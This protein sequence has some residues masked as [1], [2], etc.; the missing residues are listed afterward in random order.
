MTENQKTATEELAKQANEAK[1]P[2]ASLVAKGMVS[3][4]S[5]DEN[6]ADRFVERGITLD[7]MW[8]YITEQARKKA[9]DGCACIED[10]EVFGWATHFI[11]DGEMPKTGD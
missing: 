3:R 11:I 8:A 5:E 9:K 7:A 10:K 4:M 2:S 6:L 1:N